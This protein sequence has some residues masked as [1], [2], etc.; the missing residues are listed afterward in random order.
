VK[1][2]LLLYWV[3]ALPD[4]PFKSHTRLI[5]HKLNTIAPHQGNKLIATLELSAGTPTG[6]CLSCLQPTCTH[7]NQ[8]H[9]R[10]HNRNMQNSLVCVLTDGVA[11]C[12]QRPRVRKDHVCVCADCCADAHPLPVI[13]HTL[14]CCCLQT[15]PQQQ[16]ASARLSLPAALWQSW[17][18]GGS[19][20]ANTCTQVSECKTDLPATAWCLT[21]AATAETEREVPRGVVECREQQQRLRPCHMIH[22]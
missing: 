18:T 8:N 17:Q 1:L 14:A 19:G 2:L 7:H 3:R 6:M 22:L 11:A 21:P 12:R 20:A 16:A 9:N 4:R 5:G 13:C 10:N 15:L